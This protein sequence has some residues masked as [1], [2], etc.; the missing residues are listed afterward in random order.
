MF[1]GDL[2]V[3]ETEA[4]IARRDSHLVQQDASI[5]VKWSYDK[6][7]SKGTLYGYT[8][9]DETAIDLSP[10]ERLRVLADK[11]RS[12]GAACPV[13]LSRRSRFIDEDAQQYITAYAGTRPIPRA[14]V[15][16]PRDSRSAR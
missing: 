1:A 9:E 12:F 14:T 13:Y 6:R 10:R 4:L 8:K 3:F 11:A 16:M 7:I 15:P 5:S 2:S